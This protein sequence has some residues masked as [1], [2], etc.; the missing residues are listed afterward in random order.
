MIRAL[1]LFSLSLLAA[2]VAYG[3]SAPPRQFAVAAQ[4]Q[5]PYAESAPV[6]TQSCPPGET[7][8]FDCPRGGCAFQCAEGSTCNI[9]CDGGHCSLSCGPDATCNIECD[10]G[11]CGTGCGEGSTCPKLCPRGSLV[12]CGAK[13]GT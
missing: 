5:D 9:E 8:S 4:P 13:P 10:G 3:R 1:G 2:C 6:N 12:G 11:Q 7:C